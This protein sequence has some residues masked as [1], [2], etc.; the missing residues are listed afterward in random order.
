MS[1]EG[2]GLKHS[3]LCSG[4]KARWGLFMLQNRLA[5]ELHETAFILMIS[6]SHATA[7]K[8]KAKGSCSASYIFELK[9]NSNFN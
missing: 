8:R 4:F 6:L 7:T 1:A 9:T 2:F 5:A 3:R